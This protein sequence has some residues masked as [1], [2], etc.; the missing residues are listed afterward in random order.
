MNHPFFVRCLQSFR[1]LRSDLER[2]LDARGPAVV[3]SASG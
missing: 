1:D 3:L 2:L